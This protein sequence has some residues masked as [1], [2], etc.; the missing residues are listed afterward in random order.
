MA[1]HQNQSC[2]S[3]TTDIVA[4]TVHCHEDLETMC[5]RKEKVWNDCSYYQCATVSC[6]GGTHG[7]GKYGCPAVFDSDS[8][9]FQVHASMCGIPSF[10][11]PFLSLF[12]WQNP[13]TEPP[14]CYSIL[15][16]IITKKRSWQSKGCER[17]RGYFN[18]SEDKVVEN[19]HGLYRNN[20]SS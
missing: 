5:P 4:V 7:L 8:V 1:I 11:L 14:W 16:W 18:F 6:R 20:G 19:V 3:L 13:P 2:L 15:G 9:F 10:M 12:C 17:K